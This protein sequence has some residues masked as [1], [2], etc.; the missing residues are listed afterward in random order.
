[1]AVAR[2]YWA[3]RGRWPMN[4]VFLI[5]ALVFACP[6]SAEEGEGDHV[7]TRYGLSLVYGNTYDPTGDIGF[8]LLTG[9]ALFDY[10]RVWPHRAPQA[11]RFK[12]EGAAGATVKS[13]FR[14][15]FV[16]SISAFALYYLDGLAGKGLRP[17]IEGGIGVIYTDFQVEGQGL[18]F[19]FNPQL[20]I[21]A[22]FPSGSKKPYFTAL[23]L[24]HISNAGLDDENRGI[25]SIV[26]TV[27]RFF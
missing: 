16:A 2:W 23:R 5:A 26:F 21:G 15:R 17:Y 6:T 13:K 3:K 18:R 8:L 11:L 4:A 19:N 24:H 14:G 27:G 20:G 7:E 9:V 22:E 10:D 1:M 25:N 12:L